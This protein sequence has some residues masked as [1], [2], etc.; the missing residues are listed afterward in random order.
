MVEVESNRWIGD[1]IVGKRDGPADN[2]NVNG[3]E[4]G[5]CCH[6]AI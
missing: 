6:L 3:K 5:E 1:R 4:P 2:L